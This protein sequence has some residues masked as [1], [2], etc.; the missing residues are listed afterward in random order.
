M[1]WRLESEVER[2]GH[3]T[4]SRAPFARLPR[5]F[6][7]FAATDFIALRAR[8]RLPRPR[9]PHAPLPRPLRHDHAG[10]ALEEEGGGMRWRGVGGGSWRWSVDA[11]LFELE[12]G[13][14]PRWREDV[15]LFELEGGGGGGEWMLTPPCS[16]STF[17]LQLAQ[18]LHLT[19]PAPFPLPLQ[20][21]SARI[22]SQTSVPRDVRR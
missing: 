22:A 6:A 3:R 8:L 9:E 17:R 14:S 5:P 11:R 20:T 12:G 15:L 7:L 16:T 18:R 21:N 1:S 2:G 13:G 10:V 4:I 19:L